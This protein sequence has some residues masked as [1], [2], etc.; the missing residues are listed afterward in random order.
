MSVAPERLGHRH[1]VVAVAHEVQVADLEE[2]DRRHRLAAAL[3]GGD[4]LPARAQPR[5]GR[6]E[7]AVEVDRAVDRADDR[8]ERDD[9]QPA[10][11]L[12]GA[13]ERV[14][15]LLEREDQPDVVGLAPQ[16]PRDVGQQ[17][18]PPGAR[19]VVLRVGTGEAGCSS[20]PVRG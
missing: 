17:P 7:A 10:V 6:P 19:E 5:R 1:A 2:R 20:A 4:P 11:D 3:G 9:L 18:G 16:P 8:V 12:A 15:D 14:D 13:P